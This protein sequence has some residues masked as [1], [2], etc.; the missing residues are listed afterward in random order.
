MRQP[1]LFIPHGGG[2]CFFMDWNPP[3]T[4][5]RLRAFLERLPAS[6]PAPP[7]ALLVISA[8]WEAPV[9]TFQTHPAPGLLFD[10]HGFPPDTYQL[11]WPAPGAPWLAERAAALLEAADIATAFDGQRGFDHGVF[12]PMKIAFP[13]ASLPCLQM[14]L[15][16]GLD[17]EAHLAAGAA[18]APLRDEGVLIIGSGNSFHNM[19]VLISGMSGHTRGEAGREFDAWMEAAATDP[20]P[21]ARH[22][23]LSAWDTAPGA[24][25]AHPREEHLLPLHVVAGAAAGE[26]GRKRLEDHVMGAVESAFEYG[27]RP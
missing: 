10:Y 14:S 24:R 11:T 19:R 5:D 25:H 2:P 7:K 8:H 15:K 13:E 21:Q 4:W 22:R 18:L 1:T 27:G 20:D 23:Q 6:L 26:P 3:H 17:A 9:F 16:A 12:V